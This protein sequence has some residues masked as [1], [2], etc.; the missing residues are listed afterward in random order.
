MPASSGSPSAR[1][2]DLSSL[3]VVTESSQLPALP[4]RAGAL[5]TRPVLGR[6]CAIFI[7]SAAAAVSGAGFAAHRFR[8]R[9][10]R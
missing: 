3:P 7:F 6:L 4:G 5:I 10:R 8:R 9:A 2:F 1:S